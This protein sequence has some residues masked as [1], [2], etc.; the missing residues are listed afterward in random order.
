MPK[1]TVDQIQF[2]DAA[3]RKAGMRYA[4]IR[5]EM[6]DHVASIL[7]ETDGDFNQNFL[8]YLSR[9]KTE[10]TASYGMYRK[11]AFNRAIGFITTQLRVLWMIIPIVMMVS[12]A[13]SR[14]AEAETVGFWLYMVN[15]FTASIVFYYLWYYRI[16]KKQVYSMFEKLLFII[17]LAGMA[18]RISNFN[19]GSLWSLAYL[20]FGTAFLLMLLVSGIRL[21]SYYKTRYAV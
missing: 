7:E 17:L 14:V 2:I 13:L 8:V 3:L 21:N 20:S 9:H 16:Y 18:F 5:M 11:Q 1:L 12:F 15:A 19:N 10:L 4:D 6:T